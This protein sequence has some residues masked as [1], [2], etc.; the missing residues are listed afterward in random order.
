M[1]KQDFDNLQT[2]KMKGLKRK[3]SMG[4][5]GSVGKHKKTSVSKS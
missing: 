1:Q 4:N 5:K 3:K 2:R